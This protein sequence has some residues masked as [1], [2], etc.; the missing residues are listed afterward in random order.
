MGFGAWP[1]TFDNV[2]GL[3]CIE[4]LDPRQRQL[5]GIPAPGHPYWTAETVDYF[6]VRYPGADIEPYRE[7]LTH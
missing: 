5:L 4:R 3:R 7:G 1:F 6:A 2:N